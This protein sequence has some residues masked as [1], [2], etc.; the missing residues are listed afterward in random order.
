VCVD[1]VVYMSLWELPVFVACVLAV[2]LGMYCVSSLVCMQESVGI[3]SS[4]VACMSL[5][6]LPVFVACVFEVLLGR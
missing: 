5:L 1:V 3:T 6:L 4:L 2:L